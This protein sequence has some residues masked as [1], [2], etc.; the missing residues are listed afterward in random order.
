MSTSPVSP[1]DIRA[2]A[3]VQQELGPEYNDAVVASFVDK[4]EREVAARVEAR[5]AASSRATAATRV[6]RGTLVKG[7]AIG[8]CA[9]ALMTVAGFEH[10]DAAPGSAPQQGIAPGPTGGFQLLPFLRHQ[11]ALPPGPGPEAP[12][13]PAKKS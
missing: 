1:E 2:A 6:G 12:A 4:V 8:V 11:P 13:P 10:F 3:E 7:I 9:G 5:L